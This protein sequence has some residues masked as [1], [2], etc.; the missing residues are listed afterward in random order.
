M[1]SHLVFSSSINFSINFG[2]FFHILSYLELFLKE[3]L[4]FPVQRRWVPNG[5]SPSR[6]Y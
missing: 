4:F 3:N 5:G 6:A 1:F 2:E